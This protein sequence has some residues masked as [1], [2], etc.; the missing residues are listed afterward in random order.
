V[1]TDRADGHGF[2]AARRHQGLGL[3]DARDLVG[4]RRWISGSGHGLPSL[5]C[6]PG[7]V[8]PPAH[9]PHPGPGDKLSRAWKGDFVQVRLW[10][11][12]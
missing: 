7:P 12:I 2:A 11:E 5:G 10:Q 1:H 3:A 9:C 8:A 4:P 6:R